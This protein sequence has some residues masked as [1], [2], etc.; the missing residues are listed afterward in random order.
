MLKP[1]P[2]SALEQADDTLQPLMRSVRDALFASPLDPSTIKQ[3]LVALL[4]YLSSPAGR[5]DGNCRAVD[6]YFS[7]D[8]DLP[9]ER[10]PD[11]VQEIFAHMDTLH[12]TITAPDIAE[13]FSSTP[14]QLLEAA[15]DARI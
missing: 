3:T 2:Q 11:S 10:L 15:R 4:E 1:I 5:I 6:C 13:N 14:E 9:L 8:D 7:L 12:D